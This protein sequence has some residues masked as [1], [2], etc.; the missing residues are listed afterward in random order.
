MAENRNGILAALLAQQYQQPQTGGVLNALA[1]QPVTANRNMLAQALRAR[2]KPEFQMKE[3]TP[4]GI[5]DA[6]AL[7]TSP[8][9]ILG[10]LAGIGADAYRYVTEPESRNIQ[11]YG[12]T[13]AGL[14]PMVPS[15]NAIKSVAKKAPLENMRAVDIFGDGR[16]VKYYDNA[17]NFIEKKT[18]P[19]GSIQWLP[20][21]AGE[22]EF[23][24]NYLTDVTKG[25]SS[26]DEAYSKISALQGAQTRAAN[27][28]S[29][30][31][32]IPK[33]W[34]AESK[35]VAK[36]LVDEG[37]DIQKFSSST[38]SKS[39]YIDLAD[40]TKIRLSD[41]TLPL[42]YAGADIDYSFGG[43]INSLIEQLRK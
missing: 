13:L 26:P 37:F 7:A 43:N 23:L 17:G 27:A 11:N 6:A 28:A 9:P 2:T 1:T 8:V 20:G 14:L 18:M 40:G 3:T 35:R 32:H 33:T 42:G 15:M 39:K 30:Y 36:R 12:M 5:L 19:S 25:F 22:K 24:D 4:Q 31:G 16:Q 34:D 21:K 38:Q 10:D 41:H 29:K